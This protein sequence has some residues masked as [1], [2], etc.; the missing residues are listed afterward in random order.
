MALDLD[1]F[2]KQL[3]EEK[4]ELEAQ[5]G[6]VAH[7]NP[8][9][10]EDWVVTPPDLNVMPAAKEEMADQEEELENAA[11]VEYNLES[12]LRDINEALEKA[13]QG[14]YGLCAVG[15]EEIDEA[16]LRANAAAVTCVKHA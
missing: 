1:Y 10:P 8:D 15:G 3:E 6:T 7:R 16:R 13:R 2:R 4:S 14:K 11:S 5:L 9:A 12:R